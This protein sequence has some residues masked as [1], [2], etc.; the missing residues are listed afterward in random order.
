MGSST[1]MR[2]HMYQGTGEMVWEVSLGVKRPCMNRRNLIVLRYTLFPY[3]E[4]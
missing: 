4:Y 2:F 1:W 3:L